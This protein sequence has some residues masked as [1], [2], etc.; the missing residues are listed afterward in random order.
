M[1]TFDG[2]TFGQQAV[3]LGLITEEALRDAFEE[4]GSRNPPL[5]DLVQYCQRKSLLTPWQSHRLRK[6]YTDGFFL[7]GYRLLY[8]FASGTFGRVYRAE[9]PETGRQIAVKILRRKWSEDQGKIDQFVREG[10]LGLALKHPNIVEVLAVSFDAASDQHYIAMEFVEGG[11]LRE[12]LKIRQK[13][14]GEARLTVPEALKVLEEAAAGLAYAYSR[15]VT[16]RDMKLTNIL[17]S[18]N[19]ETKLVDFGLAQLYAGELDVDWDKGKG[20]DK[21]KEKDRN[22]DIDRTVDY[23]GL[24]RA[25]GIKLGDL[26]SDIYFLGCIAYEMLSGR[27]PLLRT[28]NRMHMMQRSR[29]EDVQPLTRADVDAPRSVFALVETMMALDPQ[30]RYQTPSQLLEAVRAARREVEGKNDTTSVPWTLFIIEKEPKL[31]LMMRDKFR[32][33]GYRVLL[34]FDPGTALQ[35]FRQRRYDALVVDAGGIGQEARTAFQ[36]VL[37]QADREQLTFAG[38][39]LLDPDQADWAGPLASHRRGAAFVRPGV[40]LKQVHRKI[41]ELL[42]GT[43]GSAPA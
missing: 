7:G 27:P 35:R 43:N 5:D 9:E 21:G 26:R 29:F 32:E 39:L 37:S 10:K 16:H 6:G 20:K 30:R 25:T 3:R 33:L 15:G 14:A 40:T 13:Q 22:K 23:N 38:V 18:T 42:N 24:E 28:R 2:A 11:N 8:H 19:K 12:W 31:Q 41:Q 4:L 1:D 17:F 36:Q 34:S